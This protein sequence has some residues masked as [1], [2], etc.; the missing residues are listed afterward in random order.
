MFG[1]NTQGGNSLNANSP[2]PGDKQAPNFVT[3]QSLLSFAA[4][5]GVVQMVWL[6]VQQAT[7]RADAAWVALIIAVA[8]GLLQSVDALVT[9]RPGTDKVKAVGIIV[10]NAGVLWAAA[11]GISETLE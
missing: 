11:L 6:A 4:M 10:I 7:A 1:V 8:I 3:E 5:T 2:S 9:S